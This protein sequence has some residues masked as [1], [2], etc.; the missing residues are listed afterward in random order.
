MYSLPDLSNEPAS[1]QVYRRFLTSWII[2]T[3]G[4]RT[5]PISEDNNE[6]YRKL[7]WVVCCLALGIALLKCSGRQ[8]G[9][10]VGQ[11]APGF[12]LPAMD[13]RQVSLSDFRGKVVLLDFWATWCGPCRL[14]MPQLESLQQEYAQN[15]VLLAINLQESPETVRGY[16]HSRNLKSLVLLDSEG[17]VGSTYKSRSIPMQVL[18]DQEGVV[19]HVQIGYS[20][21]MGQQLREEINKLLEGQ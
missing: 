20:S 1:K 16:A 8:T 7:I 2:V 12:R 13:G 14:S 19:R 3:V 15:M 9:V 21:S 4:R 18:I 17:T 10:L 11:E 6:M 5:L